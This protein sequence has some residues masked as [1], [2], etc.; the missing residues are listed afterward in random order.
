M[1]EC[2]FKYE[3]M[4]EDKIVGFRNEPYYLKRYTKKYM[5]CK[6]M[7]SKNNECMGESKCPI[8]NRK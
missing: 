8:I 3:L 6:L 7:D 2:P 5:A 1:K 4:P